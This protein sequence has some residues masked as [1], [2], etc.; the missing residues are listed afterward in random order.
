MESNKKYEC[1]YCNR[2]FDR[3]YNLNRHVQKVHNRYLETNESMDDSDNNSNVTSNDNDSHANEQDS[4]S[5]DLKS[6]ADES[7]ESNASSNDDT[8]SEMNDSEWQAYTQQLESLMRE[9]FVQTTQEMTPE[10]YKGLTPEEQELLMNKAGKTFR[11][12]LKRYFSIVIGMQEDEKYQ[13]L[14]DKIIKYRE[15]DIDFPTAIS[16]AIKSSAAIIDKHFEDVIND[17]MED[18]TDNEQDMDEE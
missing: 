2:L 14:F 1:E 16:M 17:E 15:N 5:D 12:K 8:I 10:D 11:K 18:S 13:Y 7:S 6:S 3:S 9:A 4:D